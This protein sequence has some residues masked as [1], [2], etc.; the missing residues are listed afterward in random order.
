LRQRLCFAAIAV[1]AAGSI[2]ILL[3]TYSGSDH[4]ASTAT[5][6]PASAG[7]ATIVPVAPIPE[8]ASTSATPVSAEPATGATPADTPLA[9][10]TQASPATP[11]PEVAR[12]TVLEPAAPVLSSV[13]IAALLARGDAFF[14]QGDLAAARLYYER[15]VDAGD[16]QAAIR[17][18]ETFDPVFL[19]RAQLRGAQGDVV[20]ALSWYLRARELG[21]AEA[22]ALL[23]S[24]EIKQER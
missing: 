24:L 19:G 5:P 9:P 7:A 23:E 1:V 11:P 8:S 18:G 14:R 16:G 21:A 22:G 3:L 10:K 13:D 15:A 6:V 20:T 12:S 4:L 2:G 17:L